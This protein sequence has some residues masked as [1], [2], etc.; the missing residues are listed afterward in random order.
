ML[1]ALGAM[2]VW[3]YLD[4]PLLVNPFL[5]ADRLTAGTLERGTLE[6]MAAILPIVFLGCLVLVAGVLLF[7]FQAMRNERRLLAL[8][9]RC[10]PLDEAD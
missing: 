7:V 4:V 6:V 2:T 3:L 9:D 1:V 5:V 10:L 8:V